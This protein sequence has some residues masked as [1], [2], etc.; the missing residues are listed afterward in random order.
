VTEKKTGM[1]DLD[2]RIHEAI[3]DCIRAGKATEEE[4]EASLQE[5]RD[6]GLAVPENYVQDLFGQI[7]RCVSGKLENLLP[8]AEERE[9]FLAEF[10]ETE[11]PRPQP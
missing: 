11:K 7:P 4:I 2:T 9:R 6:Q 5:L 10:G 1:A 3:M 8:S